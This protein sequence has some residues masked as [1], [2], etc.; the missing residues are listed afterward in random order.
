MTEFI[1]HRHYGAA[2]AFDTK[3]RM[4]VAVSGGR[5]RTLM[6]PEGIEPFF[7]DLLAAEEWSPVERA[8]WCGV[9]EAAKIIGL[10]IER[11]SAKTN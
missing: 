4:M 3:N 8:I 7:R 2:I 5:S 9:H 10:T 6:N 11:L 1:E